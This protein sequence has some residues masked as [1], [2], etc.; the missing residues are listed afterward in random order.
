MTANVYD[1]IIMISIRKRLDDVL[2]GR[3]LW[4]YR[5]KSPIINGKTL[6]I[7]YD[8]NTHAIV[9]EFCVSNVL[10]GPIDQIISRTITQTT[11]PENVLREY[12]KGVNICSALRIKEPKRY[13][14]PIS[15]QQ[16]RTLIVGFVPPQGYIF[17]RD[18]NKK[19]APLLDMLL[20]IRQE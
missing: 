1:K 5:R 19:L 10:K 20:K 14:N 9:G 4:E 16:I 12:F 13:K 15:L 8:P 3:K 17:L 11:S 2:D 6:V 18:E 7:V